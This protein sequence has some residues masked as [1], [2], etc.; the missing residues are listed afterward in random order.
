MDNE[1]DCRFCGIEVTADNI[2]LTVAKGNHICMDCIQTEQ[3]QQVLETDNLKSRIAVL[4]AENAE[5]RKTLEIVNARL[6]RL[7][8]RIDTHDF[9]GEVRGKKNL[10]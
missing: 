8:A 4:E 10:H 1:F 2:G 5:Y 3:G 9:K 6:R 7:I